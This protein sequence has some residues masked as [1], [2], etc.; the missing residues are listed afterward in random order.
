M[1]LAAICLLIF[2]TPGGSG[3]LFGQTASRT[4][5]DHPIYNSLLHIS[6]DHGNFKGTLISMTD[7]GITL[8][9][10]KEKDRIG[11]PACTIGIIRIKRR[12]FRSVLIDLCVGAVL[13]SAFVVTYYWQKE[14]WTPNDPPFGQ[15]L[16]GGFVIGAGTG[17][18][19]GIGE[20]A[21]FR[22]RLSV[23]KSL[24]LFR[25]HRDRLEK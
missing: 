11:I 8:L 1:K 10:K 18:V 6:T 21:F 4:D 16:L 13:T 20:S 15:A 17:A 2:C 3:I 22:L 24:D 19:I 25:K 7:S 9:R 14:F 23:N 12:F 5:F